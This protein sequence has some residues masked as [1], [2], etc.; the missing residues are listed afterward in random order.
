MAELTTTND[1]LAAIERISRWVA[2]TY[3]VKPEQWSDEDKRSYRN[4]Q[5]I[6]E[7]GDFLG[8]DLAGMAN[9]DIEIVRTYLSGIDGYEHLRHHRKVARTHALRV[10]SAAADGSSTAP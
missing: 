9:T 10:R 7:K 1:A 2:E 5:R 3:G 4:V 6:V 8:F